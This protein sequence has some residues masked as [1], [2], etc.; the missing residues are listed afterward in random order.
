MR[1]DTVDT[2]KGTGMDNLF[3][4]YRYLANSQHRNDEDN[5]Y[6]VALRAV[7]NFLDIQKDLENPWGRRVL[8]SG[9]FMWEEAEH[10]TEHLMLGHKT[11]LCAQFDS[12]LEAVK[13]FAQS[14]IDLSEID[15]LIDAL[16]Q[17][18]QAMLKAHE[19]TQKWIDEN[20]DDHPF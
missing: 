18:K 14:H 4:L 5:P 6:N 2:K 3:I 17:Q 16:Q 15:A 9:G 10:I 12:S 19:D 1:V 7:E 8:E 20:L 13:D 11:A